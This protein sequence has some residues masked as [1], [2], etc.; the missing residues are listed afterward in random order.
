MSDLAEDLET[1]ADLG[2][3]DGADAV[4]EE[5]LR[6][7]LR[8]RP[9]LRLELAIEK[10]RRGAVSLNRAAELA[11]VSA[12]EFKTE[13]AERGVPREGGFLEEDDRDRALDALE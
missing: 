11:G 7:L 4:L 2:G 5:A 10:Y 3:Y 12:E 9:E 13:L 1:L 8:R 6:T